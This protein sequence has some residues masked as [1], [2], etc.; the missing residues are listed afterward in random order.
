MFNTNLK[1]ILNMNNA[2]ENKRRLLTK[3]LLTVE[4]LDSRTK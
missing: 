1:R 3:F 4:I 2:N